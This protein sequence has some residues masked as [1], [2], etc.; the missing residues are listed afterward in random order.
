[1]TQNAT[2]IPPAT[3]ILVGYRRIN[4]C[5]NAVNVLPGLCLCDERDFC[6][7]NVYHDIRAIKCAAVL[8]INLYGI[9][10]WNVAV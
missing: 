2:D 6:R 4:L 3:V 9:F 5:F 10:L 7:N 8:N 1:M